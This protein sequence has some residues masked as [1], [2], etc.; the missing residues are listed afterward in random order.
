MRKK[1]TLENIL[2][3]FIILSPIFDITSFIF[4]KY[5]NTTVSIT[6]FIRPIIPV[7][8]ALYIFIKVD[9]NK[10]K[11][12]A[13]TGIIFIFYSAVHIYVMKSLITG[14]SYGTVMNE[15]QYIFNFTF[16]MIDLIIYENTF[17]KGNMDKLIKSVSIMTA[18][19][20]VSIYISI[21]TKT[22]SPT[23][24]TGTGYKG[25]IESGNSLSAIL[26]MSMCVLLSKLKPSI[27]INM[28]KNKK[29]DGNNELTENKKIDNEKNVYN[30]RYSKDF[31]WQL[32]MI[33]TIIMTAIYLIV[34]I[35]TRTGLIGAFLT[36]A[37]W[38]I[39]EIIFSKN[40]KMIIVGFVI[41]AIG[42]II[43][44]FV[45]S[46]TIQRRK[47]MNIDKNT[48]IDEKTGEVGNMTGDMLRLK[49]KIISGTL[50]NGYMSEAQ[51][52][53]VID[54]YNY[55][56]KHNIAGNDTRQQQLMY[57]IYLVKNQKNALAIFFGNGY[58]TNFREMVMENE[59]ASMLLNFGIFGFILYIGPF[60]GILVYSII[61]AI[62][63]RKLLDTEYVMLQLGLALSLILSW[64]A[65]Y[66]FFASSSI[67][68]IVTIGI[69]L[70]RKSQKEEVIV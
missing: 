6:T 2:C 59:L 47:Q 33:I 64:L 12:L 37:I 51:S 18:I 38:I 65:G 7:I 27:L 31:V 25:W 44:S 62:K 42:V 43:L 60:L 26:V 52:Q 69:L 11:K 32:F 5:F 67:V 13:L 24:I 23:Y 19:Y 56:K 40:K 1:I 22:S 34:F 16:L 35:G 20:V 53:S 50:E 14:C 55:A 29:A 4:R 46:N 21:I 66:V 8:A 70:L 9:K 10:K 49:N 15:L 36:I 39:S 68:I 28:K 54:L 57:N 41:I 17:N 30:N 63:N 45:G 48:I 58:K 61:A 3:L